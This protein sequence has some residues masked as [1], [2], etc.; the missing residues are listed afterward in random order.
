MTEEIAKKASELISRKEELVKFNEKVE[1]SHVIPHFWFGYNYKE[2]E[3]QMY[4]IESLSVPE[5]NKIF[6]L[7]KNTTLNY[8]SQEI[9]KI[10]KELSELKC[11]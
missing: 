9:N 11:S 4:A 1:I 8:L 10:D 6:N 5:T 7:I 3:I 2:E